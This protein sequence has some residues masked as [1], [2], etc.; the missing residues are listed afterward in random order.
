MNLRIVRHVYRYRYEVIIKLNLYCHLIQ[1][2]SSNKIIQHELN[3]FCEMI[4]QNE[5][6]VQGAL[7]TLI[8]E[9]QKKLR[10]IS[11]SKLAARN[12]KKYIEDLFLKFLKINHQ[13]EHYMVD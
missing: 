10:Q 8:D 13:Y 4:F 2:G 5:T 12:Y 1:K 3:N 9:L 7:L 6:K 11:L